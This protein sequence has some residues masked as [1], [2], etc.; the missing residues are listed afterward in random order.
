MNRILRQNLLIKIILCSPKME[1]IDNF[2]TKSYISKWGTLPVTKKYEF[3]IILGH[4]YCGKIVFCC[5]QKYPFKWL[6]IDLHPPLPVYYKKGQ[7]KQKH[8]PVFWKQRYHKEHKSPH[9]CKYLNKII[10][11]RALFSMKGSYLDW[12]YLTST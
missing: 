2:H 6:T 4:R 7:R 5:S 1:F 11:K 8:R 10:S 3:L 12:E 9:K